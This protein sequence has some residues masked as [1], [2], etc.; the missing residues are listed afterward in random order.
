MARGTVIITTN[1]C[2]GCELC[3]SVCPQE[4]LHMST[5]LNAKG[6]HPVELNDPQN[7]CTGCGL[8]AVICPD[9]VFKV[10]RY[11]AKMPQRAAAV[12]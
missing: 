1:R 5:A 12:A 3:T 10:Y 4:V 8:C 6:Y 9:V 7:R 2:K 11:Q